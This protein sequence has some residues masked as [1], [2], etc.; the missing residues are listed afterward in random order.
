VQNDRRKHP[1]VRVLLDGHWRARSVS[2][3]F[4]LA[5]L[6]IGGCFLQAQRFP[7][8]GQQG[9]LTIYFKHDGPMVLKGEVIH[10]IPPKGFAVRFNQLTSSHEFQLSI[11]LDTL[12]DEEHA[13]RFP[14]HAYVWT[15]RGASRRSPPS[16]DSPAKEEED[17][18][19]SAGTPQ[20]PARK[21][22]D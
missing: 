22:A 19:D 5:D 13:D 11:Q 6:S 7:S 15:T 17:A 1:R 9:T 18:N 20:T 4:R 2:G 8:T 16:P 21:R 14:V 3:F 10:V 12:K